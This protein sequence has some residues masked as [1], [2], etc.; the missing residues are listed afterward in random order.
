MTNSDSDVQ[1]PQPVPDIYGLYLSWSPAP[2][3][4]WDAL[5]FHSSWVSEELEPAEQ[6]EIFING[7]SLQHLVHLTTAGEKSHYMAS[8]SW[9]T[10][11]SLAW[12]HSVQVQSLKTHGHLSGICSMN[13]RP[14]NQD[15]WFPRMDK[16][17][18]SSPRRMNSP[19]L[20]LFIYYGL[21][22]D[23][24]LCLKGYIYSTQFINVNADLF[25]K[26]LYRHTQKH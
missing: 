8:S 12:S 15:L 5:N 19:F 10:R 20:C 11:D 24:K 6:I 1:L 14:W 23:T 2:F 9:R 3:R 13:P 4:L 16:D 18:C 21:L 17:G 7:D 22:T 25:Q 26:H